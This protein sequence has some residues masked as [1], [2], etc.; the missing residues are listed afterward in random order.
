MPGENVGSYP[1]TQGTLG[2]G[3]N[4][5][6]NYV[7]ANLTITQPT[8]TISQYTPTSITFSW[9]G[10]ATLQ[11]SPSLFGPWQ[12]LSDTSSPFVFS[13]AGDAVQFFRLRATAP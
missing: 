4:Y 1:I 10:P 3:A 5:A 6:L 12:N 11:S 2:A 9:S 13:T 7:G 8:L